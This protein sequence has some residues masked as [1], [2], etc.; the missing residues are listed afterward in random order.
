MD[1]CYDGH[2]IYM[3]NSFLALNN[4]LIKESFPVYELN[5]LAIGALGFPGIQRERCVV[6]QEASNEVLHEN[7]SSS[8]IDP[9]SCVC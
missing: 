4:R 1:A 7:Y 6:I 2:I 8:P 3:N 5:V 9:S